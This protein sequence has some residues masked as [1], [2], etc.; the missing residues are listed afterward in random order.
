MGAMGGGVLTG[1]MNMNQQQ[2]QH[3][4]Q[5]QIGLRQGLG[6]L[7]PG[8]PLP[9]RGPNAAM[10]MGMQQQQQQLVR[11]GFGLAGAAPF[12]GQGNNMNNLQQQ[13]NLGV[14]NV[15]GGNN[16]GN[17]PPVLNM[18]G[19]LIRD[20]QNGPG[21]IPTSGMGNMAG[22]M[23]VMPGQN[24]MGNMGQNNMGNMG[25]NS[26]ANMGNMPSN[27]MSNM[28]QNNIGNMGQNN[29]GN[30]AQ[31]NM[32]NNG[33]AMGAG[34]NMAMRAGLNMNK[35]N[36]ANMAM[37]NA[38]NMV[39][40]QPNA[41]SMGPGVMRPPMPGAPGMQQIGMNN[42]SNNGNVMNGMGNIPVSGANMFNN[43]NNNLSGGGF[44]PSGTI[45]NVS[46]PGQEVGIMDVDYRV[47]QQQPQGPPTAVSDDTSG[48]TKD[49]K[50]MA[51]EEDSS[52]DLGELDKMRRQIEEQIRAEDERAAA[53]AADLE[54]EA[55]GESGQNANGGTSEEKSSAR[56]NEE[57]TLDEGMAI[58]LFLLCVLHV[59]VWLSF[60]VRVL[61][62]ILSVI[63]SIL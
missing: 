60:I 5:Q 61:K 41:N 16:N 54:D 24:N 40:R 20:L 46:N 8:G 19:S 55:L 21:T 7:G 13:R 2:Q 10:I 58:E 28:A 47:G 6:L 3:Q 14:G 29:M 39:Q 48:K 23:G 63:H 25:H 56:K 9:A 57:D 27:S 22:N 31:S 11:P 12:V 30:M 33:M 44:N 34:N 45:G 32:G 50:G 62:W 38:M 42:G 43:N 4:Q 1:N 49:G 51:E 36:M 52:Q 15:N 26:M 59:L 18:L 53:E 37:N 35:N 17:L